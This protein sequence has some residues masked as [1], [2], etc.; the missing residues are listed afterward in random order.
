MGKTT[1]KSTV[2]AQTA[3]LKD[4]S[5]QVVKK[6]DLLAAAEPKSDK[7]D[8]EIALQS[9]NFSNNGETIGYVTGSKDVKSKDD[10]IARKST[11]EDWTMV[12][13]AS[14]RQNTSPSRQNSSKQ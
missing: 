1:D 2:G 8:R 10:G 11:G 13:R 6:E 7:E 5:E 12:V 9:E 4:G 3:L 14:T